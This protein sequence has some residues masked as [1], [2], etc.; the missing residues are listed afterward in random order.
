M[1]DA[2]RI[3]LATPDDASAIAGIYRPIV[4]RTSISFEAV[5]PTDGEMR[6]RVTETLTLYPWLVLEDAT[7]VLAYAYGSRHRPR[8]AY[9][10]SVETSVY[11]DERHRRRGL[12][13]RLYTTLLE[14]LTAQGFA[15]A[16]A[17]IALPN[18]ASVALHE[19]MG[20]RGIGVFPRVGFKLGEWWD[21]GWWHRSLSE[22][23]VAPSALVPV[24]ELLAR[25]EWAGL[26]RR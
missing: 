11:V 21:V 24:K 7:D 8:A 4:E 20:F 22:G 17:G 5:A 18:P 10:W 13:G 3:R 6:Q 14:L 9:Q 12:G 19:R 25:P 26:L 2:E 23:T 16:Y 1:P 15:N